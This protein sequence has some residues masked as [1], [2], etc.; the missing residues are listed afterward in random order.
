M[1]RA[2]LCLLVALTASA[3]CG[4]GDEQTPEGGAQGASGPAGGA[5]GLTAQEF[6]PK[7]LPDK[8][9]ALQAVVATVPECGDVE[10]KP[11]FVLLVSDAASSAAPETP[12]VDLVKA[13]C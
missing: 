1:R 7:L 11:P 13:E 8:T 2:S 12:L 4:G 10:V 3:G 6:L 5:S 9:E